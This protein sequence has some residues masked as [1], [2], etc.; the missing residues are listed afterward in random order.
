MRAPKE[1]RQERLILIESG[2]IFGGPGAYTRAKIVKPARSSVF[3]LKR[4]TNP[5]DP[6]FCERIAGSSCLKDVFN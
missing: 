5:H 1:N 4:L 3:A 6:V 2:R